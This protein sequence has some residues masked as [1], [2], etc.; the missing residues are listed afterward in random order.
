MVNIIS[1]SCIHGDVENLMESLEKVRELEPD[2]IVSPGDF[3]DYFLPKGFRRVDIGEI[4][5]KELEI[6]NKPLIVVPGSWD[7][8]LIEF[9]DEKNISV[10]GKGRVIN[11]IG[12]YGYGGA[13]T[14]FNT[15]FEPE[16]EEIEKGL[17][18][19]YDE[20]SKEKIKIQVT[21]APPKGTAVDTITTGA[22]VG[23]V[24]VRN[25]I[26]KMQPDVAICSHIH[27]GKGVDEIKNTKIINSGRFPEGVCGLIKIEKDFVS[28]KTVTLT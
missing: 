16:E 13:R 15:P 5:I 23:S 21:H 22:H 6:L 4:I 14:P 3:T 8:E 27:E 19:G 10:H 1:I 24:A 9:F 28:I 26:D 11:D 25:F 12:F 20:I 2:I 7:K 18:K 17:K